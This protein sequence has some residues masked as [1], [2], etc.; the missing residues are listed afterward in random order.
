MTTEDA[1]ARRVLAAQFERMARYDS[2]TGLAN[3]F[4][5]GRALSEACAASGTEQAALLYIDLDNFKNIN[6]SLGHEAG[7]KLL[8]QI[9]DRLRAIA[10]P[11]DLVARFGGDEFVWLHFVGDASVADCGSTIIDV[12]SK[13]VE[14][15]GSTLYV[16]TSVGVARIPEHGKDAADILRAA[17]IALYAAKA[18]GRNKSVAF[19]TGM[20]DKLRERREIEN[21]LREA[22]QK[23]TL[24]LYYQ[25]I[26]E[27]PSGRVTS[28]EALMR[29]AHPVKGMIAPDVFIPIAEQTGLIVE[30]GDWALRQ[31]CQDAANWPTHIAVAVNVSAVQFKDPARLIDSVMNALRISGL[32]PERLEL[33]VTESLLIEDQQTTLKALR[34]LRK[35]GV[36]FSLD[37]FGIGY[38]SLA[39][40]AQYPFAKVKIDRSFAKDITRSG[41]SRSIIET[42]CRL[43]SD[44]GLSVVVE[45][46]ETEA[47]QREAEKLG[48]QNAQRYLFGKPLPV[49]QQV[50]LMTQAA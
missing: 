47:Q 33:E 10:G 44:L 37:D 11:R 49:R 41:P 6:D 42:V 32:A 2:L 3:R 12:V 25:P 22:C 4:T 21:D 39:Y 43:A 36:R 48:S 50:P 34:A 7:D 45:G 15:D 13:P 30:M 5:F 8:I 18:A 27:L 38:S 24:A 17:D 29:W 46:I 23:G 35:L 28:C 1:T 31:A 26:V 16:T 40:L 9:A 19:E 20:E 14:I